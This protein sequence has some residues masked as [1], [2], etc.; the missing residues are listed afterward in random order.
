MW[1]PSV[2][3]LTSQDTWPPHPDP[4]A[5]NGTLVRCSFL[6]AVAIETKNSWTLRAK[7]HYEAW[8]SLLGAILRIS[9]L[10]DA[11]CIFSY[12]IMLLIV[13]KRYYTHETVGSSPNPVSVMRSLQKHVGSVFK[14]IHRRHYHDNLRPWKAHNLTLVNGG[15]SVGSELALQHVWVFVVLVPVMKPIPILAVI[16]F[17]SFLFFLSLTQ[18]ISP[19]P[20]NR[21]FI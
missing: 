20:F 5:I 19:S 4:D 12:A 2:R 21:S 10:D 7:Q 3:Q 14:R 1:F 16:R 8:D 15:R 13:S 11:R 17:L 6:R 9:Q 18:S